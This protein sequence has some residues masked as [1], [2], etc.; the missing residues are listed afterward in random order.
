MED[1]NQGFHAWYGME[2]FNQGFHAWY[3][4]AS[5]MFVSA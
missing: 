1:F 3:G 5:T 2:D 4:L